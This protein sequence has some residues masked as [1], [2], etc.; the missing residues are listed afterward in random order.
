MQTFSKKNKM[1]ALNVTMVTTNN[2]KCH[3]L[4]TFL[5]IQT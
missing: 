1:H 2:Y 4:L 3:H 5:L